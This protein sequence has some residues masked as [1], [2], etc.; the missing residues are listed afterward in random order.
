MQISLTP[1]QHHRRFVGWSILL[2]LRCR[3][4]LQFEFAMN[5]VLCFYFFCT[6]CKLDVYYNL[7]RWWQR[8]WVCMC[9]RYGVGDM[10]MCMLEQR[11]NICRNI[12]LFAHWSRLAELG[13]LSDMSVCFCVCKIFCQKQNREE[14]EKKHAI[15]WRVCCE[16]CTVCV[17]VCACCSN[18]SVW[19]LKQN[20][21]NNTK[22]RETMWIRPIQRYSFVFLHILLSIYHR[23]DILFFSLHFAFVCSISSAHHFKCISFA[24]GNASSVDIH[25]GYACMRIRFVMYAI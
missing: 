13:Y 20:Q 16:L 9:V 15:K 22:I 7:K 21:Q 4:N 25:N 24:T 18:S 8:M 19:L 3:W 5:L 1:N 2:E 14:E 6:Y 17:C 12:D 10:T 11:I 23:V